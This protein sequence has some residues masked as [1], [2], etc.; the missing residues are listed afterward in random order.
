[1]NR[2]IPDQYSLSD[3]EDM[4]CLQGFAQAPDLPEQIGLA[5][6]FAGFAG[7]NGFGEGQG[8]A[9]IV[10]HAL[11]L[12]PDQTVLGTVEGIGYSVE[13]LLMGLPL[14]TLESAYSRS[15]A[16]LSCAVIPH[17]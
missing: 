4:R 2:G 17:Q 14:R 5:A 9:H 16:S 8:K 10:C 6:D 11:E 15:M 12:F 7:G 13:N 1:M 3:R